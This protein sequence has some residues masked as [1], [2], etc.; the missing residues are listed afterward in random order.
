MNNTQHEN[1]SLCERGFASWVYPGLKQPK[2]FI[3]KFDTLHVRRLAILP[4]GEYPAMKVGPTIV[5][6]SPLLKGSSQR[7]LCNVMLFSIGE[8]SGDD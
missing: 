8:S 5:Q 4:T 6:V 1:C 7:T 2:I 3:K